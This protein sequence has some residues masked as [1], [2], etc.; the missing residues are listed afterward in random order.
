MKLKSL[1]LTF[2][3][4]WLASAVLV[5]L[6]SGNLQDANNFG[7][8][9]G[10]VSALFSGLALALAIYS[11][12]LQQKQGEAFENRTLKAIE[13]QTTTIKLIEQSLIQQANAAKVNALTTL[14]DQ[15]QQRIV[16]LETWGEIK[17][18]RKYYSKGIQASKDRIKEYRE[19]IREHAN[20]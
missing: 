7:G 13:Q 18:D 11:M 20:A 5:P 6:F 9:F 17:G 10:G 19:R 1:V 16:S 15:E 14:I 3:I 8:S 12:L 4:L 2:V